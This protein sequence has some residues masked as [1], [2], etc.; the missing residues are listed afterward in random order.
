[1]SIIER[2]FSAWRARA[3]LRRPSRHWTAL[4]AAAA[5]GLG[6]AGCTP[7]AAPASSDPVTLDITI[8]GGDVIPNGEKINVAVGQPVVLNVTSDAPDEI[9]AHTGGSGFA[10][11]V[12]PGT[13]ATGTL[14]VTSPGRFEVESHHLKKVIVILIAR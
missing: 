11:D 2:P 7:S 14:T 13:R 8:A 6:L 3:G 10:L 4:L 1:M 12:E 5:L 9:H